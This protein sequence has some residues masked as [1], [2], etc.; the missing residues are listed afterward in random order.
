[1]FTL[2]PFLIKTLQIPGSRFLRQYVVLFLPES[3]RH[4]DPVSKHQKWSLPSKSENPSKVMVLSMHV[5]VLWPSKS[6]NPRLWYKV[7][8][9]DV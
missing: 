9:M 1:M 7:S 5:N 4:W 6:E 2:A 3:M 8:V